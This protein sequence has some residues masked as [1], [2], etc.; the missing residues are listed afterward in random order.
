MEETLS[1]MIIPFWLNRSIDKKYGGYLTC[2]D[3]NGEPE[4]DTHKYI[5]TQTR[6]LWGFSRLRPFADEYSHWLIEDAAKQGF[7]FMIDHFWD[8]VNGGVIWKTDQ[9]G[10]ALD[11]GKL[12]YAQSFAIYA[13]TEYYLQYGDKAGLDYAE[14]VFDALQIFA[15]DNANGGYFENLEADWSPSA[16]GIYAGDRKS[17]DIHMHL[18]EAF[19]ILYKASKK[20]VHARKLKEVIELITN[21]MMDTKRGF[22]F[23]QFGA[24]FNRLP[25]INIYRT[26]NADRE[27]NEEFEEPVDSTSYGHNTELSWLLQEALDVLETN[28]K[29]H[30]ESY[31]PVIQGLLD[32]S[33][34]Y[35]F[36]YE[37]G[38]VY[39]DVIEDKPATVLDKEWWQN[40]EAMVGYL[41]GYIHFNDVKYFNAYRMTWDFVKSKFINADIGESRQLLDRI[42][43]PIISN[44]GNPW[45]GIYHT[46]RS[47][48]ECIVRTNAVIEGN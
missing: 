16:G 39:R 27:T 9:S 38:G 26:W 8:K 15:A 40:F 19:T 20:E 11:K 36:D 6:M 30:E 18:M 37:Y 5:V 44:L 42:G 43:Q 1:K 28:N 22:A 25:A 29:P 35:G 31:R 34:L 48:A 33:L 3:E 14:K 10:K 47:L 4:G 17:L 32:H 24:K 12:V 7:R 21:H 23:N 41:N 46:G 2:F 45:K 13:F